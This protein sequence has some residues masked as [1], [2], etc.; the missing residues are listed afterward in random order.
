VNSRCKFRMRLDQFWQTLPLS[1]CVLRRAG[2]PELDVAR[3]FGREMLR[4]DSKGKKDLL[5][6]NPES[7]RG[8]SRQVA[9]TPSRKKLFAPSRPCE[10]ASSEIDRRRA[11]DCPPYLWWPT[12]GGGRVSA[13]ELSFWLTGVLGQ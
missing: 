6:V 2:K 12:N 9:K 8:K 3:Q 13:V 7:I 11:G 10:V 5:T 1:L 4:L